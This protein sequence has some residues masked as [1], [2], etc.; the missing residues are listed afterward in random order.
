V[1]TNRAQWLIGLIFLAGACGGD[2][3]A[4]GGN[5]Q[6]V[7]GG[8]E[9]G[10][11]GGG[12]S[13]L[14]IVPPHIYTGYDG[15]DRYRAPILAVGGS[16]LTWSIADPSLAQLTPEDGGDHLM[17]E[18]L[19]A[20]TTTV[21][22]TGNGM[23]ATAQLVITAYTSAQRAIGQTRYF[24]AQG[25]DPS[26]ASCHAGVVGPDHTPTKLEDDTDAQIITTF[27]TGYDR[28]GMPVPTA[29]H[30]WNG[31]EEQKLG[32]V[33]FLRSLPPRGYPDPSTTN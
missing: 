8:S 26:C 2:P 23:T 7:D 18:T 10:G 31:T 32:L 14:A 3:N 22:V 1:N 30:S 33:A 29:R 9:A 15:V 17:L 21:T 25:G 5:S 24:M 27:L 16:N 13:G 20:G 4:T 11:P 19:K 12:P 28:Y 6:D